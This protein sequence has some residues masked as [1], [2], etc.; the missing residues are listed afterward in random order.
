LIRVQLGQ[1]EEAT[2]ELTEYLESVQSTAADKWP[3]QIG[4]FLVGKLAQDDFLSAAKTSA[5]DS[6]LQ[7]GQLCEAYYYAGMKH[8]LM[9]DKIGAADFFRKCLDTGEAGYFEYES[10]AAELDALKK[11]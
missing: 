3:F 7:S 5:K 1:R 10:A 4:Q 8:L 2:K 11:P 9:G 6:N